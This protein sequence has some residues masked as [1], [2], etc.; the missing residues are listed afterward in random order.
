ML[1]GGEDKDVTSLPEKNHTYVGMQIFWC[2]GL[3][4][5]RMGLP[6]SCC[7]LN[8]SVTY[9]WHFLTLG[10]LIGILGTIQEHKE[11]AKKIPSRY[12]PRSWVSIPTG[13]CLHKL[14]PVL[15]Y[16]TQLWCW[17]RIQTCHRWIQR[18]AVSRRS[19]WPSHFLS[20][21]QTPVELDRK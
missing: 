13:H 15:N 17:L 8:T 18:M 3:Q 5:Y 1:Q 14:S 7:L 16:K 9:S 11:V 12:H 20:W 6:H 21:T 19:E 2:A 4:E 10:R